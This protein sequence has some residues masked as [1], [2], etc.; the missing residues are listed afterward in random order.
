MKPTWINI[1]DGG[2][3]RADAII[4]IYLAEKDVPAI[5]TATHHNL[6]VSAQKIDELVKHVEAYGVPLLK[7]RRP[8]VHGFPDHWHDVWLN[9]DRV[10]CVLPTTRGHTE[11]FVDWTRG[12]TLTMEEPTPAE[13]MATL[14]RL[15]ERPS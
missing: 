8:L 14:R 10:L 15:S 4:L 11:V 12:L 6:H 9:L 5:L 1:N 3:L 2:L 7:C 13:M